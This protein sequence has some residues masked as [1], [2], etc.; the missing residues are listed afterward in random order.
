MRDH[1]T[2]A[3]ATNTEAGRPLV[4]VVE[5]QRGTSWVAPALQKVL[6]QYPGTE[7]IV[8]LSSWSGS[9]VDDIRA[10]GLTVHETNA[11][12]VSTACGEFLEAVLDQKFFYRGD[13]RLTTAVEGARQRPIGDRWGWDRKTPTTD[14]SPL[15]AASLAL[16]GLGT[17]KPSPTYWIL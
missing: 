3:A 2:I 14:V 13:S 10:A 17:L 1:S 11:A 4:E 6:K 16:W 12:G 7:V 9:L 8:D 15:V 5:T